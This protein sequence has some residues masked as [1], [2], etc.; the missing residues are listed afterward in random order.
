MQIDVEEV[1]PAG[2]AMDHM[3]FPTFSDSVCGI[4]RPL[5]VWPTIEFRMLELDTIM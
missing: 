4:E 5:A 1:R 3:A 2:G